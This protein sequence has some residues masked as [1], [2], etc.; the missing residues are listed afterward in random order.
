[1]SMSSLPLKTGGNNAGPYE[2]ALSTLKERELILPKELEWTKLGSGIRIHLYLKLSPNAL[3]GEHSHALQV[4]RRAVTANSRIP[5]KKGFRLA[6][7]HAGTTAKANAE[8]R[9][10]INWLKQDM[11]DPAKFSN[12]NYFN[13]MGQ[14]M[15]NA[16]WAAD[17]AQNIV[18][19]IHPMLLHGEAN[20]TLIWMVYFS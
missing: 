2:S 8:L 10:A 16:I 5:F 6:A 3:V 17:S 15:A 4:N 9:F 20:V 13:S 11:F 7:T 1:M 12:K 19:L 18:W 14:P